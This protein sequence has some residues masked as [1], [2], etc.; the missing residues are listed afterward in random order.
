[1]GPVTYQPSSF[2]M[3]FAA[4]SGKNRVTMNT[5][6]LFY[7]TPRELREWIYQWVVQF[8]FYT[9]GSTFSPRKRVLLPPDSAD[10][11]IDYSAYREIILGF[12]VDALKE[13]C[14]DLSSLKYPAGF[15]IMPPDMAKV[16]LGPK[17]SLRSG[18]INL[19][20]N[21]PMDIDIWKALVAHVNG[22]TT[23]GMWV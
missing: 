3:G 4:N 10:E 9:V 14:V 6:I 5:T 11:S 23:A 2:P 22:H 1:M 21:D 20:R 7:S 8:G 12:D 19:I 15:R 18:S 17:E 13:F 16:G